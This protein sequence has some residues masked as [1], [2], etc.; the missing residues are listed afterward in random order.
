MCQLKN[1]NYE[2][3]IINCTKCLEIDKL[4]LKALFRRAQARTGKN[5]YDEALADYNLALKLD[6]NNNE[7]KQRISHVEHL[8]KAYNQTISSN[9]KKFFL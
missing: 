7:I 6:P 1:N 4:N 3:T 8:K 5:D 9:L 2:M